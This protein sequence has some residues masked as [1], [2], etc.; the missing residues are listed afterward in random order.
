[1]LH[2]GVVE[3]VVAGDLLATMQSLLVMQRVVERHDAN[4]TS[5]GGRKG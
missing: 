1:M 2:D 3:A 5:V 4:L